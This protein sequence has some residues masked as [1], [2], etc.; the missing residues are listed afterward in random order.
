MLYQGIVFGMR[1]QT[2]LN[3]K[4]LRLIASPS[5]YPQGESNP[6]T[7]RPNPKPANTSGDSP[8]RPDRALTIPAPVHPDLA[9]LLALW[10]RLP[11]AGRKLLRQTAETLAAQ[12]P[13]K[14]RR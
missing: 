8:P 10:D 1:L 12:P 9:A 5:E 3:K 2:C 4:D 13:P 6:C 11:E 7:P 14:P